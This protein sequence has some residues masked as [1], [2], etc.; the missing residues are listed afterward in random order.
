MICI[1]VIAA[2]NEEALRQRDKCFPLTDVV[3]LRIDFIRN[4]NL[5]K[6]LSA[7][8]GKILVTARKK[9]EGGNF[10]GDEKE[11]FSLLREA[12]TLR[13]GF[14]DIELSTD[15]TF[16]KRLLEDIKKYG[17]Q[18]NLIIS[19]HDFNGTPSERKLQNI[20]NECV[21]RG[22]HIV[23]IATFANSAEDNLKILKLISYAKKTNRK[24]IALCMGEKGKMSRV[25]APLFGSHMS[26]AVLEKGLESA[27]GQLTV[28]E[29]KTIG[30][31]LQ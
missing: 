3:E 28:E 14:V 25:M 31:I 9:D 19:H 29:M 22:A 11:R 6:L 2:T 8:T 17:D 18:T 23:K 13:A 10:E 15:E 20:F 7:K 16:T 30:R 27:P 5:T 26:F 4:V 12:V 1:P 24:I 21:G